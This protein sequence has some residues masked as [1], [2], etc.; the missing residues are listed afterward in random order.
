MARWGKR[1]LHELRPPALCERLDLV[2][3]V[4][5]GVEW[6]LQ[7]SGLTGVNKQSGQLERKMLQAA[8]A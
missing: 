2:A 4:C 6:T 8:S 1:S 3:E 7:T 5:L